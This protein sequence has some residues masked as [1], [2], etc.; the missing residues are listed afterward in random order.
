MGKGRSKRRRARRQR[1]EE[2]RGAARRATAERLAWIEANTI[3]GPGPLRLGLHAWREM[4][5][6]E[7]HLVIYHGE[8]GEE[9]KVVSDPERCPHLALSACG[10]YL[11]SQGSP[12]P[13]PKTTA[14]DLWE[15]RPVP[16]P[17]TTLNG[18]TLQPLTSHVIRLKHRVLR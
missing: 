4:G 7:Q 16:A 11:V 6:L 13:G 14:W 3:A 10:R 1:G 18:K 9:L 8:S 12:T 2:R 15:S 17:L 5:D